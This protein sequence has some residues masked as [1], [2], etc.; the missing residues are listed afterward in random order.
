MITLFGQDA[1]IA[2]GFASAVTG[3]VV[4]GVVS[5]AREAAGVA[6]VDVIRRRGSAHAERERSMVFRLCFIVRLGL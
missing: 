2:G 5:A 4:A 1:G 6:S 3:D